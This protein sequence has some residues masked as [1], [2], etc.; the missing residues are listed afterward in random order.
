MSTRQCV[1]DETDDGEIFLSEGS[2]LLHSSER[3]IGSSDCQMQA[4]GERANVEHMESQDAMTISPDNVGHP[5]CTFATDEPSQ[6]PNKGHVGTSLSV[7][8]SIES[9]NMPKCGILSSEGEPHIQCH[10]RGRSRCFWCTFGEDAVRTV[11]KI[12]SSDESLL[13]ISWLY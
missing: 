5:F 11:K 3:P 1:N 4:A 6:G 8:Q 10:Q 9:R 7:S 2:S 12:R 13:N